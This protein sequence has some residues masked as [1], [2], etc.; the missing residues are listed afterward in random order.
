[1]FQLFSFQTLKSIESSTS[2]DSVKYRPGHS[3]TLP[4][5]EGVT[6]TADAS[7]WNPNKQTALRYI[8][9]DCSQCG[10]IDSMGVSALGNVSFVLPVTVKMNCITVRK[11]WLSMI[12][13]HIWSRLL[14]GTVPSSRLYQNYPLLVFRGLGASD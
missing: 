6:L 14:C 1:M 2:S 3:L 13:K 11:I 12:Y 10:F 8:I 9:L 5:K 7:A 4:I